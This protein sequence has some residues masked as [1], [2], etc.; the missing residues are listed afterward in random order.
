MHLIAYIMYGAS[1]DL[2]QENA[3][4]QNYFSIC[5]IRFISTVT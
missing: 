5:C 3:R 4:F 2:Y 1:D